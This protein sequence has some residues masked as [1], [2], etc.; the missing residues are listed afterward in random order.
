M[1]WLIALYVCGL[2]VTL[3]AQT[4]L[5]TFTR[6]DGV[7]R[8]TYSSMLVDCTKQVQSKPTT[9]G[10]PK[11]FAGNPPALSIPERAR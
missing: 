4:S 9:S 10:V 3:P 2:S 1:K 7:L 11:V 6:S 5:R 8:F